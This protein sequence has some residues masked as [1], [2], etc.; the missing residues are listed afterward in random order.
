MIFFSFFYENTTSLPCTHK[1]SSVNITLDFWFASYRLLQPEE[2]SLG[3]KSKNSAT[4]STETAQN[5]LIVTSTQKMVVSDHAGRSN[6]RRADVHCEI[7]T[8]PG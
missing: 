8:H 5:Q 2:S 7:T 1:R 3:T 6:L 4:N